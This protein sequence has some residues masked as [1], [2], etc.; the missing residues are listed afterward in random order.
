MIRA[1]KVFVNASLGQDP[2]ILALYTLYIYARTRV[3]K[4]FE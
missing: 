3:C 4:F 2:I 1:F